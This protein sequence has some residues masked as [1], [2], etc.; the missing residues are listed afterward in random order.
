MQTSKKNTKKLG[1]KLCAF[2]IP[3][4][5]V[6]DCWPDKLGDSWAV[7]SKN[8]RNKDLISMEVRTPFAC[9]YLG[10]IV[11]MS[12]NMSIAYVGRRILA[13]KVR[14]A[15]WILAKTCT[16]NYPSTNSN[17]DLGPSKMPHMPNRSMRTHAHFSNKNCASHQRRF[18]EPQLIFYIQQPHKHRCACNA[19]PHMPK[20][21]QRGRRLKNL[22][23]GKK[24][25]LPQTILCNIQPVLC[26]GTWVLKFQVQ[27][28]GALHGCS[29][30]NK[31]FVCTLVG[32]Q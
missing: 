9:S 17:L 28:C 8:L 27:T 12:H 1:D 18:R 7:P 15:Y 25:G 31:R 16:F 13:Q 21:G 5:N 23:L 30:K 4:K 14:Q 11:C 3:R 19:E 2:R 22:F 24:L 10:K 29:P 32:H 20:F 26:P 6:R